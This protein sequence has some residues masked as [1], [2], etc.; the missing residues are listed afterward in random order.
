[1][2]TPPVE[3]KDKDKAETPESPPDMSYDIIRSLLGNTKM[4]KEEI[5]DLLKNKMIVSSGFS[6]SIGP[7][8]TQKIKTWGDDTPPKRKIAGPDVFYRK[9][10]YRVV[11]STSDLVDV[12]VKD[13]KLLV[14]FKNAD[15]F[16]VSLPEDVDASKW[17]VKEN[18]GVTEIVLV[19]KSVPNSS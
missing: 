18:N 10:T 4:T 15:P 3:K 12:S 11:F 17:D 14:S 1:M 19:K 13:N 7:D 5:D 6:I 9:N 8:G 2:S 16:E